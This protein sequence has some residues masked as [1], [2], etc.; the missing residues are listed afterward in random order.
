MRDERLFGGTT[1]NPC[2][3][4]T[5]LPGLRRTWRLLTVCLAALGL[6]LVFLSPAAAGDG[7]LDP[8]F[9]NFGGVQKI[10]L[11]RNQ[12]DYVTSTGSTGTTT[13]VSLICGYFTSINDASGT[14]PIQRHRQAVRY[15]RHGGYYL[16]HPSRGRGAHRAPD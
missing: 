4:K 6:L 13:G 11:L 5:H 14:H 12:A 8:T 1:I 16:Q 2:L 15:R 9:N 7:A 10:P 3:A